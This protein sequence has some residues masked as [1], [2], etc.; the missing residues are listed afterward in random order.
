MVSRSQLIKLIKSKQLRKALEPDE[1]A[2]ARARYRGER[3]EA[4]LNDEL[5]KEAFERVEAVYMST[6]RN[7]DA[8]DVEIRERAWQ[9][10]GLLSDL[11]N[12]LI[13][14]VREGEAATKKV[15]ALAQRGH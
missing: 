5:L 1:Q 13:S 15:A 6:W 2:L 10:V 3:A 4:L 12:I 9:A 8:L 11:R 7:S 14:V